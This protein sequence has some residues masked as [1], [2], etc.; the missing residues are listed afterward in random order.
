MR[1]GHSKKRIHSDRKGKILRRYILR[2]GYFEGNI[3]K[4]GSILRK[5][6]ILRKAHFE[7]FFCK[8]D[9]LRERFCVRDIRRKGHILRKGDFTTRGN[10]TK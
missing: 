9:I 10:F 7:S 1:K 4:K 2:K 8:G 5:G 6:H 3:L